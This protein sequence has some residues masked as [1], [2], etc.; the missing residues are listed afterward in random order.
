MVAERATGAKF[1]VF[2]WD[3]GVGPDERAG[4]AGG[5]RVDGERLPFY[6]TKFGVAVS[7]DQP[8]AY[9]AA[10]GVFA[11]AIRE[12]EPGRIALAAGI[13]GR[14]GGADGDELSRGAVWGIG[15]AFAG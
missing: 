9:D 7:A 3:F 14:V 10:G 13:W 11:G 6:S 15:A 2:R 8:V 1:G 12:Y 5:E 4:T